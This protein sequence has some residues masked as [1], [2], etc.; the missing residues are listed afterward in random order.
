VHV[1]RNDLLMTAVDESCREKFDKLASNHKEI[2]QMIQAMADKLDDAKSPDTT[3]HTPQLAALAAA[4]A[5]LTARSEQVDLALQHITSAMQRPTTTEVATQT[6]PL[7]V[8]LHAPPAQ[9]A[10]QLLPKDTMPQRRLTAGV[11]CQ[12]V[13]RTTQSPRSSAQQLK[14]S[15]AASKVASGKGLSGCK[16]QRSGPSAGASPA[17]ARGH[18]SDDD[19]GGED[20]TSQRL[21]RRVERHRQMRLKQQARMTTPGQAHHAEQ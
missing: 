9:H 1:L 17:V 14:K 18:N 12:P 4:I 16:R 19:D 10:Q 7:V 20:K 5:D 15:A 11:V 21:A 3:D 8:P 2:M 6:S 13:Q